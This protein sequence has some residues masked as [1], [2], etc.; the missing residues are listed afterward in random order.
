MPRKESEAV[1]EGN[2]PV[3]QQEQFESGEPTMADVY[4]LFEERHDRKLKIIESYFDR[5]NRKLDEMTE[6]WR[7]MDQCAA[8]L[9]HDARQPRLAMEA[10]EQTNMKTR[11]RT[12]GAAKAVQAM[13]GDSFSTRRVNPGPKT[14]SISFG[15]KAE[16]PAL[17]CRDDV[18]V[19]NGDASPKSCL[20]SSEIRSP[21]AAGG[22]LPTGKISPATKTTFNQPP[23]RLSTEE[24]NC[25]K[26]STP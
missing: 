16:P 4:R 9:E 17:P 6:D 24:M 15:M 10:D 20:P 8:S 21:S 1:P 23:L 2:G 19:E 13:H 12:E 25:K 26:T 18:L 3:P 11:E 7:N 14:N 22:S 5:W